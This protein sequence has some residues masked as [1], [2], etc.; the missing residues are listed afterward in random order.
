MYWCW[1]MVVV[2][3]W[4]LFVVFCVMIGFFVGFFW[5]SVGWSDCVC[6]C[7][8]VL[9]VVVLVVCGGFCWWLWMV[10]GRLV[11][12]RWGIVCWCF[13]FWVW[14]GICSIFLVGVFVG[15][16]IW[17]GFVG[18]SWY[19]VWLVW[20][21]WLVCCWVVVVW[22]G[23][24]LWLILFWEC[25]LCWYCCLLLWR[26]WFCDWVVFV[27]LVWC[28]CCEILVSGWRVFLVGLVVGCDR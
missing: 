21:G 10:Y 20:W 8:L 23:L 12:L 19:G 17:V 28:V 13:V 1:G 24:F 7:V 6:F 16:W 9:L 3:C 27:V 26:L 18:V 15:V 14:C 2:W 22:V 11:V 4:N 25:F 5:F